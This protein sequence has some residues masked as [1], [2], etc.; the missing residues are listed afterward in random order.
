M[1]EWINLLHGGRLVELRAM[2]VRSREGRTVTA[3]GYYRDYTA[4]VRDALELEACGAGSVYQTLNTIDEA[5]YARS[6]DRLTWGTENTTTDLNVIQ[7]SWIFFDIDAGCPAGISS[8]DSELE[9]TRQI[10]SEISDWID[11]WFDSPPQILA[12]SG[13]GSHLYVD[14]DFLC[15]EEVDIARLFDILQENFMHGRRPKLDKT[16]TNLARLTKLFGTEVRKGFQVD[17]RKWRRS[18]IEGTKNWSIEKW[19]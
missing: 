11:R 6:P 5:L 7:R 3:G 9:E 10:R 16:V 4:C 14:N 12:C 19:L 13:N 1:A 8:T 2:K 17:G 18:F 15:L